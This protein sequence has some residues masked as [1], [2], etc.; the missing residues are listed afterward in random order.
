MIK[1]WKLAGGRRRL[2]R[3]SR[4]KVA[5]NSALLARGTGELQYIGGHFRTVLIR[6]SGACSKSVEYLSRSFYIV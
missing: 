6:S 2:W 1:I 3:C 5:R 4:N